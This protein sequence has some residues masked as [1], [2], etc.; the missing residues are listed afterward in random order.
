M[1]LKIKRLDKQETQYGNDLVIKMV[2]VYDNQGKWI[3]NVKLNDALIE[4]LKE[5]KIII[6]PKILDNGS[7]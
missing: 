5:A 1:H 4:V 2:S 3:R 6:N 7:K